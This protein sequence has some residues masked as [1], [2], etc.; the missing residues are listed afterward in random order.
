M[1][2][3][4]PRSTRTDTLFPYTT[5]FRSLRAGRDAGAA[6][7]R[8]KRAFPSAGF[9]IKDRDGA[10]PGTSRFLER[11]GQFL[12]LIGLAALA[13]AGTGVSNGVASYLAIKRH[14]IATLKILGASSADIDRK[15]PRLNYSH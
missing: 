14:G 7:D 11:M 5:L 2:R 9:E 13:I 6:G 1:I 10:A 12:S 8:L 4:P 15:S 3:R